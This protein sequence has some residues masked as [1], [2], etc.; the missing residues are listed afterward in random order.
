M[1][2]QIVQVLEDWN[3]MQQREFLAADCETSQHYHITEV[4]G[5][6]GESRYL[7]RKTDEP[8]PKPSFPSETITIDPAQILHP[9]K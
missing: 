3:E 2:L 5:N 1:T 7:L 4:L 9:R 6:W 8:F